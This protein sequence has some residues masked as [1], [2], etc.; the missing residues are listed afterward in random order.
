VMAR[1][2]DPRLRDIMTSLVRHL[3]AFVTEVHLTEA[4][5]R[6][7]AALVNEIG[8]LSNDKHNEAVL[9]AGSLGISALVCMLNNAEGDRQRTSQ[10][11]LGPFWRMN[12]PRVRNGD[13]IVRAPLDG[14]TMFVRGQLVDLN[15]EAV[16]DAE[17]D[18]WQ[19][20][21]AGLYENQDPEQPTMNLRGKLTSDAAGRFWF[22][23]VKPIGYPIPTDGVVGRL[24]AAQNRHP[25]RPAHVHILAHKAG[26]RTLIAQLYLPDDPNIETDAQFGVRAD[27]LGR[28]AE[29]RERHP[30]DASIPIP[31]YSLEHTFVMERGESTLPVPPIK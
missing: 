1:T 28:L 4:E 17:V 20:S 16:G 6:T 30:E 23:S 29:H 19:C 2:P 22:R 8:Q 24:L 10:N 31:W 15:G 12:S 5:F 25:F 14:S 26:Y 13:S 11:L 7:G 27:L 3:H 18:V 21:P 9:M